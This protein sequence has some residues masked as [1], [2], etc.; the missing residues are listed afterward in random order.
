MIKNKQDYIFFLEEDRKALGVGGIKSFIFDDIWKFQRLMRKIEYIENCKSSLISKLLLLYYKYQYKKLSVLLGFSISPHTFDYGLNIAHYGDIVVNGR[1]K[2]GK[3]CRLHSGTCIGEAK[4][5][6]P[7][8]GDN[9]YIGPGVKILGDVT[10]CK[11]V[12]LS[13][14]SVIVKNIKEE[15]TTWG[16]IP[17]KQISNNGSSTLLYTCELN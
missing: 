12:A 1:T 4:G 11:G 6:T 13:A 9:V 5:K 3:Y 8:I 16:G 14:N 10:I 17:A 7:I 2:V 15:N